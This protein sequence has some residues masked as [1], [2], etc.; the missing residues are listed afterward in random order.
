MVGIEAEVG[1]ICSV[2]R[3]QGSIQSQEGATQGL[4]DGQW[5]GP[6]LQGVLLGC[7]LAGQFSCWDLGRGLVL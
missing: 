7:T 4:S 2:S 5:P 6:S 1:G 3:A